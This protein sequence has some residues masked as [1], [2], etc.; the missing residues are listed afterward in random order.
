MNRRQ[1]CVSCRGVLDLGCAG[2]TVVPI[3]KAQV[4]AV[5]GFE[6]RAVGRSFLL[7]FMRLLGNS[8]CPVFVDVTTTHDWADHGSA[9]AVGPLDTAAGL[10]GF[11]D[12]KR[13]MN[14]RPES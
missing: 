11:W 7:G 8:W 1:S 14:D 12:I 10:R 9:V 6:H 13:L 4:S 2:R 5:T 3:R